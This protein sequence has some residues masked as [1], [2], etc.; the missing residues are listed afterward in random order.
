M[1]WT[2]QRMMADLADNDSSVRERA[3]IVLAYR[4]Q[5]ID[6]EF[7]PEEVRYL[8]G[9]R[10]Q[11]ERLRKD[12]RPWVKQASLHALYHIEKLKA[13]LADE[14]RQKEAELPSTE[15]KPCELVE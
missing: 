14:A 4:R 2:D 7:A 8:K 13:E 15:T 10:D 1:E 6:S 5:M 12:A 3:G 11:V 9:I